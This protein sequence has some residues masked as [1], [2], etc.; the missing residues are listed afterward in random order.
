VGLPL[1]IIYFG[2]VSDTQKTLINTFFTGIGSHPYWNIVKSYGFLGGD[3]IFYS[4]AT[5]YLAATPYSTACF[6]AR[7]PGVP[8]VNGCALN[9]YNEEA[10]LSH[11]YS[12]NLLVRN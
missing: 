12:N 6:S 2:T 1:Y 8:P 7:P 3:K 5:P 4:A 11:L 9:E 10:I